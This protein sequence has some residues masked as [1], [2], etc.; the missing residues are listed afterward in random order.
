MERDKK[1]KDIQ[2]WIEIYSLPLL[3]RAVYLVSDE[4]DAKDLVQDV[5]L[6]ALESY[7]SFKEESNPKTWLTGILNNKVA[8]FYRKKYRTTGQIR[9][10]YFFD[11]S[12]AWR[13]DDVLN[14]WV[15]KETSLL[16]DDE[17]NATLE[18]CLDSL[19]LKWRI[20][21]KLYYLEEKKTDMVCQETGIS[22]T[23][24]WKI[25]QRGRLQLR[26][27]LEINWFNT[28]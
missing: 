15:D 19:P 18:N 16:N 7:D 20:P 17:F 26:E 2:T 1:I 22:T 6:A 11:E 28:L 13:R 5:F 3:N 24:L 21:I 23:N 9:L 8:D 25:L 14:G 12:G 4:Q 27:C 10:D